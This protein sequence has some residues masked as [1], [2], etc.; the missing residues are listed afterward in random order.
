MEQK[1]IKLIVH[2]VPPPETPTGVVRISPDAEAVVRALQR[3]TGL[4]ARSIVSQIII[5]AES[6]IECETAK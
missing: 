3:E 1:R 6:L 2:T 4:T 5:Q